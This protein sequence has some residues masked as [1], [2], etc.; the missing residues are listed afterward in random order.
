MRGV[1]GGLALVAGHLGAAPGSG[2]ALPLVTLPLLVS[3]AVLHFTVMRRSM[4]MPRAAVAGPLALAAVAMVARLL[5]TK[6]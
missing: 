6:P 2:G 4:N 1:T 3:G 5:F